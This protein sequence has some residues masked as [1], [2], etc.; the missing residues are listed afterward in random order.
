MQVNELLRLMVDKGASDL[1]LTVPSRPAV[2]I[3]GV[4]V[5]QEDLPPLTAKDI[6]SALE[7]IATEEQRAAFRSEHELDFAY[8][9]P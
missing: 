7:Q 2:R 4:L 6:E 3:D 9:I 1:H 5:A 8:A